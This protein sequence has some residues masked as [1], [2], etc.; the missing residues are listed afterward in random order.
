MRMHTW[1][2][3]LLLLAVIGCRSSAKKTEEDT[4]RTPVTPATAVV[5]VPV[6]LTPSVPV[7]VT[8]PVVE[9]A[10]PVVPAEVLSEVPLTPEEEEVVAEL[11]QRIVALESALADGKQELRETLA[12]LRGNREKKL[13]RIRDDLHTTV[14]DF[15]RDLEEERIVKGGEHHGE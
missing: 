4:P 1:I 8:P 11:E 12:R 9:I 15:D 5:V 13:S 6:P 3:L 7:E 2:V 14:E 10:P